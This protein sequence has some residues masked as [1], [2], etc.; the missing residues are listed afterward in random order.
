MDSNSVLNLLGREIVGDVIAPSDERYEEGDD[1]FYKEYSRRRPIA[2]VEV[3]DSSDVSKVIGFAG[4]TGMGLAV[5]GGGHSVLGHS[6]S[7]GGL[8]LDLS[9]LRDVDVD[10]EGRSA[11]AGGGVLAG[12]YTARVAEHGLV[13]GFG[14]T[15]SVGIAGLTLGGGIGLLHRKLGLT[16]DSLLGAEIV[17]ADG[18]VHRINAEDGPDLFWAIRGGG[19]NFGVV[20]KLHYRLHPIDTVV[21]GMLVLPATPQVIAD[22][23]AAATEASDDLSAIAGIM[24]APPM[25]FL[26]EEA[27]GQMV[28]VALMVHA[29]DIAAGE[30]EVDRFRRLSTPMHDGLKVMPYAEMFPPDEAGPPQ[31]EAMSLRSV[32][33][34]EFAL[35]EAEV[36]VDALRS[37]SAAM[38]VIQIRALGGAVSR[39]PND[40]TAFAHRNRPLVLNVAAAYESPS[41]RPEYEVWVGDLARKLRKGPAGSYLNFLGD[42]SETS[43]REVYPGETWDRLVEVKSKYDENNLFSS[44]HNIPPRA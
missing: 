38:S 15:G 18:E 21:G 6:T 35:P 19:G 32:F 17:T 2:R 36:V 9:A 11:W 10:V 43:V 14:D 40:A 39:I 23:V 12:D 25:P 16:I 44:N 28:V 13:T 3:A 34:D 1:I 5:R 26:P 22:F 42:D 30:V 7:D 27:H 4:D 24:V 37:S 33:S 20:T 8:V 31:P 41:R 29:G